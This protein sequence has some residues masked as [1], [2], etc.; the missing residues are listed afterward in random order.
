MST[1][2]LLSLESL[3]AEIIDQILT[4]LPPSSLV[5]LSGTSKLLRSHSQNDLLWAKFVQENVPNCG[6]WMSPLPGGSWKD[7]Y[8]SHHPYWFL[9]RRKIWVSDR[10]HQGSTMTG[11]VVIARYDP[12]RGC[13]EAYRLVAEHGDHHFEPWSWNSEVIIHTFNPKVSLFLDDPVIKLDLGWHRGQ[14]RLQREIL[15]RTGGAESIQSSIALCQTIPVALQNPS[16]A[17]WPPAI[18]PATQRVR[19]DSQSMFRSSGHRPRSLAE[20]SDS[21]FRI[22]KWLEFGSGSARVGED[23]MTFST[24]LEESYTPTKQKPWQGIWVGDYSGHGCEFMVIIQ[25]DV[26][27]G[28]APITASRWS[29]QSSLTTLASTEFANDTSDIATSELPSP[30]IETTVNDVDTALEEKPSEPPEDGSCRG[31]LEAI[32]LTGDPNVPRGEYT[33]IAEDIG[34]KGLLRIANEQ[35]FKGARVVR[36]LG[37]SAAREFRDSQCTPGREYCRSRTC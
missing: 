8:I 2:T 13:I 17:L 33:W 35:M 28:A 24:I 5:N 3:P 26:D 20:A 31:R 37:H 10:S 22:R 29:S 16:M 27:C 11:Q 34:P 23:V 9:P 25:K 12:R 6:R 14:N 4:L 15:M 36:S 1:R 18:L 21:T 19:N 7:L 30:S 32:K